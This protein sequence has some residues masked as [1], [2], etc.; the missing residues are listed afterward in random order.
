M[1]QKPAPPRAT[2]YTSSS[3][4]SREVVWPFRQYTTI[5]IA[6]TP[7]RSRGFSCRQPAEHISE[8][9]KKDADRLY[10]KVLGAL[11]IEHQKCKTYPQGPQ[12]GLTHRPTVW[13]LVGTSTNE[14]G[15]GN[16]RGATAT[17]TIA[18]IIAADSKYC[19][20]FSCCLHVDAVHFV[21]PKRCLASGASEMQASIEIR[22]YG[23]MLQGLNTRR[24]ASQRKCS[25]HLGKIALLAIFFS[26][27]QGRRFQNVP[28]HDRNLQLSARCGI[29][30]I[31]M[32][33]LHYNIH[34]CL[35]FV[36]G[37]FI[38]SRESPVL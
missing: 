30:N 2:L 22:P 13:I 27:F 9:S 34:P 32:G 18:P 17:R 5:C 28:K 25:A 23:A 21:R 37:C 24:E 8:C 20:I 38:G 3:L 29:E 10:N 12:G 7:S 15:A 35:T 16:Q 4:Q 19:M 36:K 33:S 14:V 11:G 1:Q 6:K 26:S 31:T